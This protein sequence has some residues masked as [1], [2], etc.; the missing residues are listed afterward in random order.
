MLCFSCAL[1][2]EYLAAVSRLYMPLLCLDRVISASRDFNYTY[3][4]TNIVM[5]GKISV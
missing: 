2:L 3:G 1:Y 4:T 5:I